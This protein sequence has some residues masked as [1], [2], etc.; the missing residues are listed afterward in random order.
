MAS[1]DRIWKA[2]FLA[3]KSAPISPLE[4]EVAFCFVVLYSAPSADNPMDREE[5]RIAASLIHPSA[6]PGSRVLVE[7][8]EDSR[9][10]KRAIRIG[11]ALAESEEPNLSTPPA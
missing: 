9:G 11:R 6:V 10:L 5:E 8:I 2:M 7:Y 3:E 4:G 1:G